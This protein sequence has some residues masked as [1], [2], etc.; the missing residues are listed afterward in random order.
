MIARITGQVA[1]VTDQA[2]L[3]NVGNLAYEVL[4]PRASL[5]D[6]ERLVGNEVTL[7]TIHYLEGSPAV[8]NLVPRLL[9][10]VTPEDREFFGE[11][12][13]VK[14]LGMRK[15][16]RAMSLPPSQI[17]MA[18]ENGDERF[19]ASLP[20][21]GKRTATQVVA[22]L[23]GKVQRFVTPSAAPL[24][25]SELTSA[26]KIALEIL[27]GWGDRRADAQRWI[28]AVVEAQ[29]ALAEPDEIV[30]AVYRLKQGVQP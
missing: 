13:K 25:V 26:Q 10:F 28:A 21:I 12:A 19:L 8:G 5:A 2:V 23:R 29:P 4:V 3:L 27:V 18:I 20:E 1:A 7:F 9:G 16:L 30:R 6:L 17:A 14:G 22:Q 15:V 11:L 24:P